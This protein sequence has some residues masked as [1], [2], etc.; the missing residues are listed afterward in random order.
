MAMSRYQEL[1]NRISGMMYEAKL[2]HSCTDEGLGKL[3]GMKGSTMKDYRSKK[4]TA[5]I[6]FD[7]IDSLAK[8]A[9]YRI[10][11]ERIEN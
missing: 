9:G 8:A 6:D 11:F 10:V 7:K 1:S 3:I 5:S 2:R 4:K